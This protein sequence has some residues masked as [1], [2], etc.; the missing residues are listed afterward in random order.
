MNPWEA[1]GRGDISAETADGGMLDL[2]ERSEQLR[3]LATSLETVVSD[4][5]GQ[6]VLLRGEAGVGK[7]AVVRRF[8]TNQRR[9][10]RV[11]WGACEPLFTPRPLGPFVDIAELAG[12]PLRDLLVRG[13]RPHQ[14]LS[15][16]G[17]EVGKHSPTILVLEDLHWADEATLDVVRLLSRRIDRFPALVL[18]TY[19]DDDLDSSQPLRVVLGELARATGVKR[20][21]VPRL[22]EAAVAKMAD[23]G[24]VDPVELF[25]R[26]SGN[27]F[28]VTEVLAAGHGEIPSTVR[29]AVLA[30]AASLS[31]TAR[32]LLDAIAVAPPSAPLATLGAIAGDAIEF[33]EE[34]IRCGMVVPSGPGVMFR[35]ELARLV[36]EESLAPDRRVALH[37]RAL[38]ALADSSDSARLA[39][40]ADEAG[41]VEAVL[42]FAPA[43]A[44]HAAALSAHRESA[45]HY[46]QA[47]RSAQKL[48]PEE[49]AGLLESR[50]YECM[51]TDQTDAAI[52]ALGV[53]T[54]IRR[55]LGDVRG[56]G[57][58]LEQISNVLWCP[59]RVVEAK[60]AA[61]QA[62][63]LLERLAPG[64]ELAMAY[65]RLAQLSMDAEEPDEAV[66]WGTRALDLADAVG[67]RDVTVHALNSVGTARM[68]AGDLDGRRLLEQSLAL[69]RDAGLDEDVSR[70][71]THL[72]W[73]AQRRRDYSVALRYLDL[74]LQHASERGWELRRGY[75]LAYRAQ[76]ELEL[77]QWDKAA[78][79]AA[80]VLR[81]PRR[82]RVPR[83]VALVVTAR[84]RARRAHHSSWSLLAE[85]AELARRGEELQAEAPVAIGLAEALWLQGDHG[86]VDGA[87]G[88]AL[89]LA[90][91]R[92]S[93]WIASEL[94]SWRR[95][96]GINDDIS[97]EDLT[98]PYAFELASDWETAAERW[99]ELGC[100][101]EAALA[102]ANTDDQHAVTEGLQQLHQLGAHTAA[103]V[104][105]RR[106]RDLGAHRVPRGPR[107]AT[108]DNPAGLSAREAQV[109]ALLGAGLRNQ[110]IADQ[111]VVS[112]RTVDHHVAAILRKLGVGNRLDAIAQAKELGLHLEDR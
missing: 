20:L 33:V 109:L 105:S 22:S 55:E 100:P 85:A 1:A 73:T 38:Q 64:R 58:A 27:P 17:D 26:T 7:T 101:Y 97:P 102:L 104:V 68:S 77:G 29:D 46:A 59:G 35:H 40:H 84:V 92:Q 18:A 107:P 12:G 106:L 44:R 14:V 8:C 28:F 83:I 99:Q 66:S 71:L 61:L 65:C 34:C 81:E 10:S 13:G 48:S 24:D 72:A 74:A 15:A 111:L 5:Q 96:A 93:G 78:D 87:T 6:L 36:I 41:D 50:A 11:L 42:R 39:Y 94:Y 16:L 4:R 37:T 90:L 95:R 30:R 47:L 2:L 3:V 75:Q 21:D 45:A 23:P 91:Q 76:I 43:A 88:R 110:D 32:K 56:E 9:S 86:A 31:P 54:A 67:A 89:E 98:G 108:R 62:V 53:A 69:A 19:R 49:R 63:S 79:T 82:S 103:A 51:V 60:D 25:Q 80:L 112:P 52:E 57:R 70:A